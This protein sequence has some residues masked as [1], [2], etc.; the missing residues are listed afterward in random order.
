MNYYIKVS[1]A[2]PAQPT[3][4]CDVS[5]TADNTCVFRVCGAAT[6]D[7]LSCSGFRVGYVKRVVRKFAT[8]VFVL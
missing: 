4:Y 3:V 8:N 1:T 2:D 7:L 5:N 6:C